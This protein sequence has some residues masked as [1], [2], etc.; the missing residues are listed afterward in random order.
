[1]NMSGSCIRHVGGTDG[2]RPLLLCADF[3]QAVRAEAVPKTSRN[4]IHLPFGNADLPAPALVA[5]AL[6]D[7]SAV[8]A[9]LGGGPSQNSTP[10]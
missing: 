10:A 4:P 3:S 1:M 2:T 7:L 9:R 5:A 6:E 8:L